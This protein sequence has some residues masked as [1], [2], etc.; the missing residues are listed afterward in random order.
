MDKLKLS[1]SK[2]QKSRIKSVAQG[3]GAVASVLSIE[4]YTGPW[5]RAAVSHFLRRTTLGHTYNNVS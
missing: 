5:D 4:N 1:D 3:T 2:M